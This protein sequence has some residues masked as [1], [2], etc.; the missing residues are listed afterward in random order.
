MIKTIIKRNG[1]EEDFQPS[2]INKW[3]EWAAKTLGSRVDWSSVVLDTVSVLPEKCSSSELQKRLIKTCLDYNTWLYH[4]MAGRL[5]AAL[6]YKELYDGQIPSVKELHTKLANIGLMRHLNYSDDEYDQVEKLIDHKLDMKSSY[7]ELLQLR[8]KY[9]VQNK[10]TKTQ[11]ESQQFVYMRMAMALAEDQPRERRMTDVAKFYEH[12]SH[13]R[14]NAPTPNYVNLGTPHY[15]LASC[16]LYTVGDNIDSLAV[17][18]HIAYKMTAMSAGIGA[19]LN[20]RSLGDPVRNGAIEHQG[21]L[22][23]YRVIKAV[24][25]ANLQAGRGGAA[26]VYYNGYDPEINTITRLR[27]VKSTADKSIRGIDYSFGANKFLIR[28]AARDENVFTFNCFTAPDLYNAMYKGDQTE[29]E[30]LYEKYENDPNFKKTYVSARE[31]VLAA[32]E[33]AFE[34]G[35]AYVHWTDELNSHTPHYDTIWMSNLCAEIALP[36]TPYYSMADLYSSEDHGRGEIA[37]CSLGAVNVAAIDSDEQYEEVAYYVLWM[38]DR[39]I[40]IGE[41][42]FPHLEVTAKA[43]MNAGV[44]IVGH[45]Y[46]MAK[47][48]KKY[49]TQEG[50]DFVHMTAERHAYY[51]IKASLKLGKELGN[52]PWMHK[53]RWPEGWTPLDTYNRNV[54]PL[55][56]VDNQYDWDSLKSEIVDNGGIRNSSLIAHMPAESSANAAGTTNGLYPIRDLTLMKSDSTKITY[57]AAPESEKLNRHYELAWDISTP[58]MIDNYAI[59]QKWADQSISADTYKRLPHGSKVESDEIM[60]DCIQMTKKG[61]KTRYYQNSKTSDGTELGSNDDMSC[62]DGACKL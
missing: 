28:K 35:R 16:C 26:T 24:V 39:C 54:D 3:G 41:Y 9:S 15:G 23:Y 47:N 17:G 53:T 44:G 38:I 2:K 29:F 56:T 8:V 10:T 12:I 37:L 42:A 7:S 27:S 55:V 46:N 22:P 32:Y 1:T 4:R 51:C 21:K 48:K 40:H 19:H 61:M 5:Y 52:A 31:T 57:W 33:Q 62:V 11:Y 6:T 18:D 20:T 58:D 30:K 36:T 45:A 14:I 34:T 59:F 50:K 25:H 43:R 49:S 60:R 13:K